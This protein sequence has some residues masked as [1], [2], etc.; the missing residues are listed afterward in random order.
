MSRSFS[1]LCITNAICLTSLWI[2]IA[3]VIY[4]TKLQKDQDILDLYGKC[5]LE[6]ENGTVRYTCEKDDIHLRNG[7]TNETLK[8]LN[9]AKNDLYDYLPFQSLT[10]ISKSL[11][12]LGFV[13]DIAVCFTEFIV[14]WLKV[15]AP[16][17][18]YE[19]SFY[20]Y[21]VY[22][23]HV[24]DLTYRLDIVN[25]SIDINVVLSS[26]VWIL[27]RIF[28]AVFMCIVSNKLSN[29]VDG[30]SNPVI[31]AIGPTGKKAMAGA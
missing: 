12:W 11:I 24:M 9:D 21:A 10:T 2:L 16:D 5:S 4:G 19:L 1:S 20:R 13:V 26:S 29:E 3:L 6:F 15:K 25:S 8:I 7:G 28:V 14:V 18:F 27:S 23:S 31:H 22:C 30:I 17:F